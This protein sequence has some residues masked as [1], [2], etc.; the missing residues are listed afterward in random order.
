MKI[1]L[2]THLV[3][4]RNSVANYLV[5]SRLRRQPH[6][7]YRQEASIT[8][9]DLFR[10]IF[11]QK[12]PKIITSHDVLEPFKQ[13]LSASRDVIISGQICGSKLQK[14]FTLGD[15]C[16]LPTIGRLAKTHACTIPACQPRINFGQPL[17]A[18]ESRH[19]DI[20]L[21]HPWTMTASGFR[22]NLVREPL[23]WSSVSLKPPKTVMRATLV[24]SLAQPP[25]AGHSVKCW[26]KRVHRQCLGNTHLQKFVQKGLC[27]FPAPNLAERL[28]KLVSERYHW[29]R[30]WSEAKQ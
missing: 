18:L 27:T 30:N 15:G 16:W 29:Q 25:L 5:D 2:A 1:R 8:W 6:H 11:G 7:Q 4:Q 3:W 9:C 19:L 23:G 14:V 24:L 10:P 22:N 21:R 13:V 26:S 17:D 20:W 12:M 28:H